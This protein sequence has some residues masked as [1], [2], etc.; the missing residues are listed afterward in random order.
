LNILIHHE[1]VFNL[2]TGIT[3]YMLKIIFT[4]LPIVF[5]AP[6]NIFGQSK[7]LLLNGDFSKRLKLYCRLPLFSGHSKL[8]ILGH[9]SNFSYSIGVK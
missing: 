8:E 7:E 4:L 2:L 9:F 6:I 5:L 3:D 1:K